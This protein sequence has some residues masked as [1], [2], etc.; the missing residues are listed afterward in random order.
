MTHFANRYRASAALAVA[1]F[2]VAL[3]ARLLYASPGQPYAEDSQPDGAAV[4]AVPAASPYLEGHSHFDEKDPDGT[5]RSFLAAL[6][7]QNTKKIYLQIPPDTFDH[8]GHYDVE[9]I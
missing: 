1:G 3:G 8:P 2:L 4:P 9:V 5:L 7:R 6:G